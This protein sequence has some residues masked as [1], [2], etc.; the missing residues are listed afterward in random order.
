LDRGDCVGIFP[1]GKISPDGKIQRFRAGIALVAA[2]SGAPVVPL[3]IRGAFDSIPRHRKLPRRGAI[4]VHVGTPL[5]FADEP[6]TGRLP[7][8]GLIE[9]RHRLYRTVVELSGQ[10]G[11]VPTPYPPPEPAHGQ[12]CVDTN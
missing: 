8:R 7:L 10:K 3:G 11:S 12:R 9:F 2:R 4:T 5:R 1:E 6:L